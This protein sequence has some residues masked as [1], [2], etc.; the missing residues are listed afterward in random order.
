LIVA[1]V[2]GA[3][4][5]P[6]AYT[7]ADEPKARILVQFLP[8]KKAAV[9]TA[10]NKIGGQVHFEFDDLHT[11]A[12]TVPEALLAG[13]S[14]NP[15]IVMIEEDVRRYPV[16]INLSSYQADYAPG[17]QPVPYGIDMVQA[18][19]VWDAD[20]DGAVDANAPTGA[21][22]TICII[23]SGFYASHEDLTA[24]NVS[25]YAGNLSWD[26]DGSGHGTHVAGTIAAMNNALGVVGVTP[27]TAKIYVVRVFGDDGTWAY[28]SSLVDA[29]NRC[30]GA[31]ANII[32]MSLG[33]DRRNN[34]EKRSFDAL[35]KG[36][37]LSVAAA[38][39]GGNTRLHYPAS[40]D[41]VVSVAAINSSK[42]VADFSQQN[43]QVELSAPGVG[44]LSTVP[45]LAINSLT[46]DSLSY[47]ANHI[48]FSASGSALGSLVDG[49]LCD[50]T[51]SWTGQVVL[52]ERGAISFY[53]KVIYVQDSGAAAAV[54]YNNEPGNFLG[55]LGDGNS[56]TIVALSLS[57]FDGQYLV[58]NKLGASGTVESSY[59]A[60]TSGYA[61]YDG[62]SMA[63]PHVSAVAA[64]V[65]SA[66]I[67]A[68]NAEIRDVL[69]STA[70]D[71]GTAGR[72]NAYGFGL[73]Q[74][75]DALT[76]LTGSGGGGGGGGDDVPMHVEALN[77]TS[78]PV[79]RKFWKA[80]VDV[81]VLDA[82]NAGVANATVTGDWSGSYTRSSS[83]TT[84]NAGWCT[85]TTANIKDT[86]PATFTVTD[87]TAAGYSYDAAD[88]AVSSITV[89]R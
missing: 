14:R 43:S 24:V 1:L 5:P 2:F 42:V 75:F 30:A 20:R 48:E 55:T 31:G 74:A 38:G 52:C 89:N 49:G 41:T 78:I 6:V 13:L 9:Q 50:S 67:S 61:Y 64:L 51:G 58:A 32:S 77:G 11:I 71:L 87:L 17:Y 79:N 37:I 39:N 16:E 12:V 53:D 68:T 62:T 25:G 73:V 7:G 56:S 45:Y 59:T 27:G 28:S 15:N 46:V 60:Q 83:C 47:A 21:N 19:D 70:M 57:Q 65:W 88:N 35:Y 36:G 72:D 54:I 29:A 85:L 26:M 76:A 8:S 82:D 23:D 4:A 80:S 33:G 84:D 66:D 81:L 34:F 10:L 44:V 69:T 18:V 3:V 86:S 40:Y 63:T 22:R